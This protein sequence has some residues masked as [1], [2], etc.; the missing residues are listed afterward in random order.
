MADSEPTF[1]TRVRQALSEIDLRDD[2]PPATLRARSLHT[3]RGLP[4]RDAMAAGPQ[5]E[6]TRQRAHDRVRQG[7]RA[8]WPLA[9]GLGLTAAAAAMIVALVVGGQPDDERTY[10]LAGTAGALTAVIHARSV[11]VQGTAA[12]VQSDSRYELW[13][14]TG[15][16]KRPTLTSLGTFGAD[17]KGTVRVSLAA[18]SDIPDGATLAVTIEHD[19]DPKPRLPPV[20]TST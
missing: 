10:R 5:R 8:R 20:L 17:G 19:H 13:M 15:S 11:E 9:G 3:V 4:D 18:R 16:P 14:V 1:D 6:A 12:R 2:G 7:R